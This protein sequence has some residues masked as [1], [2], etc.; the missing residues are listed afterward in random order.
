MTAS[1]ILK[2]VVG[3]GISLIL[4][5]AIVYPFARKILKWKLGIVGVG[6]LLVLAGATGFVLYLVWLAIVE[7]RSMA[8]ATP[9]VPLPCPAE[10]LCRA[11]S[12]SPRT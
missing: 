5:R 11:I 9:S 8:A 6:L 7:P 12:S 3:L 10:T 2:A 1:M 4:L